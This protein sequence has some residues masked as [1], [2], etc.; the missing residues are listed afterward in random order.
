MRR[1]EKCAV[2]LTFGVQN[3]QC[4][5][6]LA[7]PLQESL[8]VPGSALIMYIVSALASWIHSMYHSW[9]EFSPKIHVVFLPGWAFGLLAQGQHLVL[10]QWT[11]CTVYSGSR[12]LMSRLLGDFCGSSPTPRATLQE[13]QCYPHITDEKLS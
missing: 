10:L 5:S 13:G 9:A 3:F 1:R 4:S 8:L 11:Q 12:G 2:S 6:H 7:Q